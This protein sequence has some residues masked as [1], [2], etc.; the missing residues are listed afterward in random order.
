MNGRVTLEEAERIVFQLPPNEQ[1]KLIIKIGEGLSE[2]MTRQMNENQQ[3]EEYLT[4][5]DA[6]L[7]L[8]NEIPV[9]SLSKVDSVEDIRQI[10]EERS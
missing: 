9:K 2:L 1:L 3:H 5:V 10:R 6:F 7:K 8:R 4:R